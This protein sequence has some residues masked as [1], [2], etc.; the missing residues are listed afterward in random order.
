[1]KKVGIRK[2]TINPYKYIPDMPLEITRRGQPSIYLTEKFYKWVDKWSG[3]PHEKKEVGPKKNEVKKRVFS[4]LM[5]K[6]IDG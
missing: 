5:G 4:K 1:M 6:H 2:F 3:E